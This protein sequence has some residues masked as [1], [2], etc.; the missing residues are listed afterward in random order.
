M[1]S[2]FIYILSFS[3]LSFSPCLSFMSSSIFS[4]YLRSLSLSLSPSLSFFHST[5]SLSRPLCSLYFSALSLWGPY[6]CSALSSFTLLSL[7]VSLVLSHSLNSFSNS[8]LSLFHSAI[9]LCTPSVSLFFLLTLHSL[10]L[11]LSTFSKFS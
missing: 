7:S 4:F 1:Q 11:S 2:L 3:I 10:S 5:L 8:L 9:S 6:L